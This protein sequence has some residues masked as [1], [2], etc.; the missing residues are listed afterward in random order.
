MLQNDVIEA[1][2]ERDVTSCQN[3]LERFAAEFP[4]HEIIARMTTLIDTLA[5]PA[6]PT[7]DR[8]VVAA[9][10]RE[11]DAVVVPA[12]ERVFGS[13][14][15]TRWLAPVWSSLA[16]A[17]AGLSFH[18]EC[19]RAHAGFV[20]L[21]GGNWAAAEAHIATI[22]SWRRIPEPLAWMTEACFHRQGLESVW[23]LLIELAWIDSDAFR[24][25]VRRLDSAPLLRLWNDF[26][27][28]LGNEEELDPSWFPAW[29]LITAPE[30]ASVVRQSQAGSSK[31]PERAARLILELLALEKQGR[32][33][34]LVA[35]RRR[36][37][38]LHLG[39]FEYYMS[40]R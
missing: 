16:N 19:P 26:E 4:H 34:E 38:D 13:D 3:A 20:F 27:I 39:L 25:L 12:A 15:A 7:T 8:D 2:S 35:Q 17:A 24:D 32:H 21:R 6:R 14:A 1:L 29:L 11:L 10:I 28:G 33:A 23:C 22:S 40:S 30:M 5:S 9:R 31:L 37:R 36:L 18:P